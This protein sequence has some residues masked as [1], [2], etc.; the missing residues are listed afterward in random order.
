ML[1][2][3]SAG[4]ELEQQIK[5]PHQCPAIKALQTKGIGISKIQLGLDVLHINH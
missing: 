2:R 1:A 3:E 4:A 5:V